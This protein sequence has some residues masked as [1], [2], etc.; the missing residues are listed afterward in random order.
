M[1]RH[2]ILHY[3]IQ[4][5]NILYSLSINAF[6]PDIT[7]SLL[8]STELEPLNTKGCHI[9]LYLVLLGEAFFENKTKQSNGGG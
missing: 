6:L 1:W 3:Y 2:Y 5:E 8:L 4:I 9:M 7:M